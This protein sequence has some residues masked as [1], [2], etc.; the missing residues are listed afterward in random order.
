M[1]SNEQVFPVGSLLATAQLPPQGRRFARAKGAAQKVR[2]E[3]AERPDD[4]G[5][6]VSAEDAPGLRSAVILRS[7]V[8]TLGCFGRHGPV[9]LQPLGQLAGSR[10]S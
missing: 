4:G 6:G 7:G 1:K 9:W 8:S 5:R 10:G 2:R 3:E